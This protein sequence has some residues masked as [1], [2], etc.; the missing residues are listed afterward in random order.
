MQAFYRSQEELAAALHLLQRLRCEYQHHVLEESKRCDCKY[1]IVDRF[2]EL[3]KKPDGARKVREAR[4][5][6][7]YLGERNG[8]PELMEAFHIISAMTPVE[9]ARVIKRLDTN[10]VHIN[11]DGSHT[12]RDPRLRREAQRQALLKELGALKPKGAGDFQHMGIREL[13]RVV[14]R[15]KSNARRR[16]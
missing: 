2:E 5:G 4:D 6:T 10:R 16:R 14:A 15:I 1:G 7:L 3:A 9:F 12:V 11:D 13:K 8:C